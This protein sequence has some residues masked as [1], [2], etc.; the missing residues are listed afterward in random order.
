MSISRSLRCLFANIPKEPSRVRQS[1][2][3]C[4]PRHGRQPKHPNIKAEDLGLVAKQASAQPPT[5]PKRRRERPNLKA[6]SEKDWE[7]LGKIYT[8]EQLEAIKAGEESID[9]EDLFRQG[10][11]REDSFAL[12][13]FD[14]LSYVHPVVDKPVRA[15]ESNYDPNLRYK[16]EGELLD[17]VV[18]WAQ[19]LSEKTEA[20]DW[21][22]FQK[23]LRLTVGKEEAERNPRSYLSPELPVIKGLPRY[24]ETDYI[25]PAMRRLMLQTGYT[26]NDIKNF[27]VKV[28][29]CHQVRNTTRMGKIESMYYLAIAGNGNGLV[30]IGEGKSIEA[31]DAHT[32]ARMAAIRNMVPIPRYEDRT[33]FGDVKGKVGATTVEVMSRPPG[34]CLSL[35]FFFFFGPPPPKKPLVYAAIMIR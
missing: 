6:Y 4:S 21:T 2:H 19:N 22:D 35:F 27:R 18:D 12:P 17:D 5:R 3:T 7:D 8:P 33:I 15:P 1:F 34:G 24:S 28:L 23:N 16:E 31:G 9:R 14:D 10:A 25:D 20:S 11:I 13:Y 26:Q 30:G 29:V 32:Q